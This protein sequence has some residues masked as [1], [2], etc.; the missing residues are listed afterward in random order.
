[1]FTIGRLAK[2]YG[3]SRSTL[4]YY[5]SIGLFK[6]TSR[7]NGEYRLYSRADAE[8]LEQIRTYRKAGLKLK[9]I[10]LILDA[11][12]NDLTAILENRLEEL[13]REIEALRETAAADR[14]DPEKQPPFQKRR[15]YEQ[16]D[17]GVHPGGVGIFGVGHGRMACRI[18]AERSGKT[19]R[20]STI[21]LHPGR[22]HRT[23]PRSG[24]DWT[25]RNRRSK[26][27]KRKNDRHY[28]EVT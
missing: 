26:P 1:M 16:G 17:M 7:G 9:D 22:G 20:I 5:D 4:L 10:K 8:R 6:P 15:F 2:Q 25:G 14:R 13:N 28:K 21:P 27:M 24:P 18:R 11:P 23:D 19:Q 12:D 3:L